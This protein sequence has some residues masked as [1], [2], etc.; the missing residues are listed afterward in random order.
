MDWGDVKP[1]G[2]HMGNANLYQTEM[3]NHIII[4]ILKKGAY[5][6]LA[7]KVSKRY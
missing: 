6:A 5:K 4:I 7:T 2:C 1:K 3:S